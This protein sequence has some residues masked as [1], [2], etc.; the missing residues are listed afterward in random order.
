MA[1][2]FRSL[3]KPTFSILKSAINKPTLRP[4]PASSLLP[5][6]SSPT[7]SRQ[8][9]L[10]ILSFYAPFNCFRICTLTLCLFLN[11]VAFSL[12]YLSTQRCLQLGSLHVWESIQVARGRCLRGY[13]HTK[14]QPEL[15]SLH[16]A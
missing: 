6:R 7:F 14:T 10:K 15:E 3:S 11:W 13:I 1:S 8:A 4:N 2:R 5:A 9:P 16:M 12:C